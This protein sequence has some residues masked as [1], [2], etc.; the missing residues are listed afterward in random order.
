LDGERLIGSGDVEVAHGLRSVGMRGKKI[1][2]MSDDIA[3]EEYLW[4]DG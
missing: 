2:A 1:R 4:E 3:R